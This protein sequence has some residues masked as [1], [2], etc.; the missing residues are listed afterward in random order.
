MVFSSIA[1]LFYFL[2]IL[3]VTYYLVP[4][5]LKNIVLL[6]ASLFFYFFGEPVYVLLMIVSIVSSYIFG[7]LIDKFRK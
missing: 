5:K 7:L 4:N 6:A 3:L 1:F 2:P